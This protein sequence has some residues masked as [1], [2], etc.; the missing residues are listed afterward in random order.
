MVGVSGEGSKRRIRGEYDQIQDRNMYVCM[1]VCMYV[2]SHMYVRTNNE[3]RSYKFES[4]VRYMGGLEE[5][6]GKGKIIIIY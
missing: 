3:K 2:Y 5:R 6:K 4:K 1:Y